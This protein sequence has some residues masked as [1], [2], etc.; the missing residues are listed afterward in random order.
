M[1]GSH[2]HVPIKLSGFNDN[3]HQ[4]EDLNQSKLNP[5]HQ[6][7]YATS[8]DVNWETIILQMNKNISNQDK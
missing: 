3:I 7:T 8:Q 1:D 4:N 6:L 5:R 2:K